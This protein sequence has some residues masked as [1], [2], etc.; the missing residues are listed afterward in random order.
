MV[1]TSTFSQWS[2]RNTDTTV[3]NTP[4]PPPEALSAR[5]RLDKADCS[6]FKS[7]IEEHM[8]NNPPPQDNQPLEVKADYITNT[9]NK[10]ATKSIP[11]STP[12][13][14]R[15]N[16]WYYSDA[17]KVTKNEVN[18]RLKYHRQ[19]PTE[20]TKAKLTE[21]I[22]VH[23]KTCQEAKTQSWIKWTETLNEQTNSKIL[24]QRVKMIG[25][26]RTP[27]TRHPDP[28]TK[29]EEL[30]K[31][32][33][34]RSSSDNLS[35]S[36]R[37]KLKAL[38]DTRHKQATDAINQEHPTDTPFTMQE[39]NTAAAHRQDTSPG[40]D[41]ISFSIMSM[42]RHAPDVLKSFILT[43]IN[44]SWDDMKLPE[45]WKKAN[46]AAI[47][48]PSW[49][50]FGIVAIPKPAQDAFRPI[51]LL[52][53]I[54]KIMESMVLRRINSTARPFHPN[55][56]GFRKGVG[57]EDAIASLINE[58]SSAKNSKSRRKVTAVFPWPRKGI[59]TRQQRFH[60]P[61]HD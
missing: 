60:H 55:L 3:R 50:G 30:C 28:T 12:G 33:A 2:L 26:C 52:S 59:R 53:C 39:L 18:Y 10:A 56:L 19:A 15:Q 42:V 24:W 16:A 35:D 14:R 13:P 9:I 54:R 34:D 23:R 38:T 43:V 51:S 47:P 4:L 45:M 8:A 25:G 5:W 31:T 48:K 29:A 36:I 17:M 58:I 7:T 1:D 46:L 49:A 32:F 20:T 44:Q 37:Q 22:N 57:T 6:T 27:T 61:S 11:R 41:Q 21:A 40:D